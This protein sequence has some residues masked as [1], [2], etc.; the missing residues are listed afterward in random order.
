[1]CTRSPRRCLIPRCDGKRRPVSA[2]AEDCRLVPCVGGLSFGTPSL[3]IAAR[4]ARAMTGTRNGIVS[5]PVSL[6]IVC[7]A[8]NSCAPP[9]FVVGGDRMAGQRFDETGHCR[10]IVDLLSHLQTVDED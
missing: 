4:S 6:C 8:P 5:A 2:T 9:V 3:R 10:A 1:M 7:A